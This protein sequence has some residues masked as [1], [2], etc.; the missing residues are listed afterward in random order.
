MKRGLSNCWCQCFP[1]NPIF[2]YINGT[3]NKSVQKDIIFTDKE[4]KNEI[5]NNDLA[6][7]LQ[8]VTPINSMATLKERITSRWN[9]FGFRQI[10]TQCG[11]FDPNSI[12]FND[13]DSD[14]PQKYILIV[15]KFK[16]RIDKLIEYFNI[17]LSYNPSPDNTNMYFKPLYSILMNIIDDEDVTI[18]DE[19][20]FNKYIEELIIRGMV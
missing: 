1:L 13:S 2:Y 3:Q 5:I 17:D 14:E 15:E 4:Q 18:D 11:N 19:D 7:F 8:S 16:S 20:K 9:R 10:K 6:D 12:N